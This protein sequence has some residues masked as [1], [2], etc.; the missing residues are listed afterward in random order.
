[1]RGISKSYY[2]NAVLRGVDIELRRGEVVALVGE[3]GAGKSTLMN[4]LFGMPVIHETGGFEG[5][6]RVGGRG[7]RFASPSDALA[8][9]IGM[10][11]QEF[12]LL[13]EMSVAENVK[14]N[15]EPLGRGPRQF[16]GA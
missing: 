16:G 10:V 12:M 3:N 5:E 7:V 13:P 14:L 15:R 8:A 2:G 1:M 6:V 9:G 4:L 11:H